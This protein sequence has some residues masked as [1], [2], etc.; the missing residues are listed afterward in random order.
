MPSSCFNSYFPPLFLL[1]FPSLA[2]IC[3]GDYSSWR[4]LNE[5]ISAAQ[6]MT[7]A[8]AFIGEIA[9]EHLKILLPLSFQGC[10]HCLCSST[11]N[12]AR[13]KIQKPSLDFVHNTMWN[14]YHRAMGLASNPTLE[15][16]LFGCPLRLSGEKNFVPWEF[17]RFKIIFLSW[18]GTK[19]KIS[20]FYELIV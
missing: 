7:I 6:P 13:D 9:A 8:P 18:I 11:R 3:G 2:S 1:T 15:I 4:W 16:S 19:V 10:V 12:G 5:T 20:N 14:S 17:L